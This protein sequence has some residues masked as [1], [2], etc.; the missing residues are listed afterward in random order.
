MKKGSPK[1]P[2]GLKLPIERIIGVATAIAGFIYASLQ[3]LAKL[4]EI[5]QQLP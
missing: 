3:A 2:G 1:P 4:I 5:I